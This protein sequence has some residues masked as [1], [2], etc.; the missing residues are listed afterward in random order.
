M[1]ARQ[2]E[3][4]HYARSS[5][6]RFAVTGENACGELVVADVA[7]DDG[8]GGLVSA[9]VV[10]P[11]KARDRPR[12]GIVVAHGG[13]EAG[14]HL[15]LT[16]AAELSAAG[17]VVLVADVAFPRSGDRTV[18][19]AAFRG[20][21][22]SHRRALDVLENELDAVPAGFFGHSRGG[23]EGAIL[24][25]VE[26]RLNAFAIAGIGSPS[27]QRRETAS[28]DAQLAKYLD[29]VMS[30]DP[31]R[32]LAVRGPRRLLVQHGRSDDVVT[33]AEARAMYEAAAP[34]KTWREYDCGHDVDGFGAARRDRVAF[35]AEAA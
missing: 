19:E 16:Q 3:L 29:A 10:R 34:P 8:S 4:F 15:F 17:F 30:F 26:P 23:L 22:V 13:F 5:P 12:P 20:N 18:V 31:A 14:K 6:L 28:Q 25:V 21:V 33:I 9:L 11:R 1:T 32:Y 2:A 35:F 24:A 27:H 7:Y